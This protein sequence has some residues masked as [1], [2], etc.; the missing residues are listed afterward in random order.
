M[1][2]IENFLRTSGSNYLN[3]TKIVIDYSEV[4]KWLHGHRLKRRE[5][6]MTVMAKRM[7]RLNLS[8]K[9]I[10]ICNT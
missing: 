9:P 1:R 4:T 8:T 2:E 6:Q 7:V 5:K 3:L 10:W